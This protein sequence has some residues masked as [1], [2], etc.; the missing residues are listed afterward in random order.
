MTIVLTI[1]TE[2]DQAGR[3][4]LKNILLPHVLNS[5]YVTDEPG[6]VTATFQNVSQSISAVDA[7]EDGLLAEEVEWTKLSVARGE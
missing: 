4:A 1:E 7:L 2:A 6:I 3:D 5:S